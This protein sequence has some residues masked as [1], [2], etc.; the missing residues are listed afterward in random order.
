MRRNRMGYDLME[1]RQMLKFTLKN[2][3]VLDFSAGAK[4]QE[5]IKALEQLPD[6]FFWGENM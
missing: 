6:K 4:K 5:E 3:C 1:A 2:H